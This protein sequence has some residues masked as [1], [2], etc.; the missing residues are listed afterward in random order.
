MKN[1]KSFLKKY[2]IYILSF[3][4]PIIILLFIYYLKDVYPFGTQTVSNT[5]LPNAYVPAYYNLWDIVYNK[6]S[7]FFNFNV[8]AGT[9]IYDFTS[10]Y[11]LLNPIDWIVLLTP[12]E[13]IPNMI[14]FI[15]LIKIAFISL[16]ATI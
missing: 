16:S 13:N 8:G 15:V 14:N 12:R 5:D 2:G 3:I 9:S 6:A 4:L 11:G 1:S 10:I 7:L